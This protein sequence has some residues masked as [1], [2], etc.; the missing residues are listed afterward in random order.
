MS[1]REPS[2]LP[3][4]WHADYL[5][6]AQILARGFPPSWHVDCPH[7]GAPEDEARIAHILARLTW[8]PRRNFAGA[9]EIAISFFRTQSRSFGTDISERPT[10][11]GPEEW[12]TLMGRSYRPGR[13]SSSTGDAVLVARSEDAEPGGGGAGDSVC[14]GAR[15]DRAESGREYFTR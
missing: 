3:A 1:S 11:R 13:S 12:E 14:T 8:A 4:S 9:L 5:K 2:G 10:G 15:A 7:R 6:T